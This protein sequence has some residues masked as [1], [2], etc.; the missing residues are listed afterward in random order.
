MITAS[1]MAKAITN[2]FSERPAR[3]FIVRTRLMLGIGS[4]DRFLAPHHSGGVR[5]AGCSNGMMVRIV[6][7]DNGAG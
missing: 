2:H 3:P 6:V 4:R 1:T 5:G 7:A